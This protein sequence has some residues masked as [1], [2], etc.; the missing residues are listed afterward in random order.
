M[1]GSTELASSEV[2]VLFRP[3][4]LSKPQRSFKQENKIFSCNRNIT[5]AGFFAVAAVLGAICTAVSRVSG[6]IA[7]VRTN[8]YAETIDYKSYAQQMRGMSLQGD[9][10][11]STVPARKCEKPQFRLTVPLI[12][13]SY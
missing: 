13:Y 8:A 11:G 2:E 12:R 10:D 5:S 9:F 1:I 7:I 4:N 3:R 6:I